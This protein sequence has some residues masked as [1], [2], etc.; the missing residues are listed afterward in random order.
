MKKSYINIGLLILRLGFSIGFMTHGFRKFIKAL[1]GDFE[2]TDPL[3]IGSTASLILTAFAEFIVPVI[4]I[5][6]WK[7]RFFTI[8]PIITMLVAFYWR[9]KELA[10]LYLIAFVCICVMGPG[11]YSID[12]K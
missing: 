9:Q 2:F 8:F 3:N 1:I 4:I 6:G 10:I 11:K 12:K 7:T 5:I